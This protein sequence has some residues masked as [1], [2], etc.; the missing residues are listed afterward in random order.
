MRRGRPSAFRRDR[1]GVPPVRPQYLPLPLPSMPPQT[2]AFD[3]LTHLP[4]ALRAWLDHLADTGRLDPEASM[5]LGVAL[6]EWVANLAQHAR[7]SASPRVVVS[8]ATH[9]GRL[10][11]A[12]EDT[13][14]GFD[15][16][17]VLLDR[18]EG[19][20][21]LPERG[22]GLLMLDAL[23]DGLR[24]E[25]VEPHRHRLSFGLRTSTDEPGLDVTQAFAPF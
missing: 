14:V 9:E 7:W 25:A 12:V 20:E 15:L 22:M 16:A 17:S 6:H 21:A 13:S 24:Y 3:D 23:S 11:C 4:D 18:R 8:V 5:M 2:Q 1:R 10:H 19:F